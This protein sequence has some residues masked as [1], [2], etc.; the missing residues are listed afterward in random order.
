[1]R[2]MGIT[3]LVKLGRKKLSCRIEVI[4]YLVP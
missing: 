3:E 2:V 1:M 4:P